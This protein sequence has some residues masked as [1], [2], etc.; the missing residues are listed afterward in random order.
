MCSLSDCTLSY[1]TILNMQCLACLLFTFTMCKLLYTPTFLM[2]KN[3]TH[4][5]FYQYVNE[6]FAGIQ[7]MLIPGRLS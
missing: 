2:R 7:L 4:L 1:T 3:F 5:L 6:L